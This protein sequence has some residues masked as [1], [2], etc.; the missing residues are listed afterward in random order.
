ML[1]VLAF[2]DGETPCHR[3]GEKTRVMSY[4]EWY[5]VLKAARERLG[6]S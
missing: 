3:C 4:R 2:S 1:N 6:R 5:D